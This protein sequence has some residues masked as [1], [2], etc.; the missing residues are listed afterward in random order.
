MKKLLVFVDSK[1]FIEQA[2]KSTKKHSRIHFDLNLLDF[3]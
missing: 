2:V 1:Q 3:L